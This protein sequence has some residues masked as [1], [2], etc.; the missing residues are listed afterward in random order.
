MNAAPKNVELC[1]RVDF[2]AM[3]AQYHG[4]R[5][6]LATGSQAY[7]GFPNV[8]LQAAAAET[9]IVSLQDFDGFLNASGAGNVC[10]DNIDQAAQCIEAIL[11][12]QL[13]IDR[14]RVNDYLMK[15]HSSRVIEG[16]LISIVDSTLSR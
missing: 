4:C 12:H 13:Q 8:L 2:D 7:E 10:K 14:Q 15:N 6:L 5:C 11:C 1:D 9:P 16:N 3:P